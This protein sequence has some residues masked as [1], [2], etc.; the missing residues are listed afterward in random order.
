MEEHKLNK[1]N[2]V[3]FQVEIEVSYVPYYN[4]GYNNKANKQIKDWVKEWLGEPTSIPLYIQ[5]DLYGSD[6]EDATKMLKVKF[7]EVTYE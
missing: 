5:K 7:K 1:I 3:K 2:R 6:I 4:K